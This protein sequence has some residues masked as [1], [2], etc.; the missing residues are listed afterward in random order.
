MPAV[1]VL[2][3]EEAP[4][5]LLTDIRRLLD[6]AFADDPD[7]AF[8]DDDW[9]HTIGGRH[10]AVCDDDDALV[11]HAAV[12]TRVL[13][14]DRH[15]FATGYVEGVATAPGRHGEGL[16]SLAMVRVGELI[17]DGFELGAL[18]TGRHRF[19]ERLGW[20]R[21]QGP[22]HAR[23]GDRWVRTAEDDG[24]VMVLRFGP[25]A[26]IDLRAPISCEARPGDDW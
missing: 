1:R 21:W 14:V 10:V 5:A 9:D 11:A 17:R 4:A 20:E 18:G 22:T 7:G 26:G 2:T 15:P 8:E 3:A 12:V 6:A 13:Q 19:Y 16:G 24:A 25:S 23:H